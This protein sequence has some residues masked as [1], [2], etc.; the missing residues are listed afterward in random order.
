VKVTGVR[1]GNLQQEEVLKIVTELLRVRF[2]DAAAEYEVRDA[3]HSYDGKLTLAS[4]IVTDGPTT[5]LEMR[6]GEH[7]KRVRLYS[8]FPQELGAIPQLIDQI[9]QVEQ[10]IGSYCER[11]RSSIGPHFAPG[12]CGR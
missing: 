5:F 6:I 2:F 9:V 10:W 7:S 4:T 12:E 11:P 8:N 1:K 3:I